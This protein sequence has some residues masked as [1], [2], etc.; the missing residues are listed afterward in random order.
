[1]EDVDVLKNMEDEMEDV[2]VLKNMEDIMEDLDVLENMEDITEDV[3]V[4][5]NME[6]K[7]EDVGVLK[8]MGDIMEN[9]DV[10]KNMKDV[11]IDEG[12][13]KNREKTKEKI[14][15][16]HV[17]GITPTGARVKDMDM[18]GVVVKEGVGNGKITRNRSKEDKYRRKYEDQTENREGFEDGNNDK[19]T[20]ETTVSWKWKL[21]EKRRFHCNTCHKGFYK[22][23]HYKSH[24]KS[25]KHLALI[26]QDLGDRV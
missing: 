11:T 1:M 19:E 13:P 20:D 21:S 10:F 9:V 7:M 8:N 18:L 14:S 6:D 23:D 17:A 15:C 12:V 4:L 25:K 24:N 5:K 26:E 2:G 16:S 22:Y 3:D